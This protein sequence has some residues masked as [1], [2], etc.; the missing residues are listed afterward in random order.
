[1][2]DRFLHDSTPKSSFSM[3]LACSQSLSFWLSFKS[4]FIQVNTIKDCGIAGYQYRIP[5]IWKRFVAEFI[6][7]MILLVL[8]LVI[9]YY[10]IDLS[11]FM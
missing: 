5:P 4:K 10:T 6:D 9:T 7:S 11:E 8:K 3:A 1:M 2:D